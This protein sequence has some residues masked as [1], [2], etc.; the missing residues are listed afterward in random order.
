MSST[1]YQVRFTSPV[2]NQSVLHALREQPRQ[3]VP[4]WKEQALAK[5]DW[6][7]AAAEGFQV[8]AGL[9]EFHVPDAWTEPL[10]IRNEK[11]LVSA[12]EDHLTVVLS[13]GNLKEERCE[14]VVRRFVQEL[15]KQATRRALKED[16]IELSPIG[17]L[18]HYACECCS[19]SIT[20]CRYTCPVCGR[21]FCY[22]HRR[23]ETHGCK[24]RVEAAGLSSPR[25]AQP[26]RVAAARPR[27]KVLISRVRCG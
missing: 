3:E 5:L 2:V 24:R 12:K 19:Q 21:C 11:L 13:D 16:D 23:A 1:M 15:H 7:P 22:D 9:L 8:P 6:R 10:Q 26:C 14:E 27:S 25:G 17:V 18:V 20:D 4:R